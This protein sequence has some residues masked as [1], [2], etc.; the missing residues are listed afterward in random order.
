MRP[1]DAVTLEKPDLLKD[2]ATSDARRRAAPEHQ[3]PPFLGS[4]ACS[5]SGHHDHMGHD[6]L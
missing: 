6:H 3:G 4:S 5:L 2:A 1:V